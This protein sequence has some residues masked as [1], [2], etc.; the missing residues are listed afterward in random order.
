MDR[1][2][3]RWIG[4]VLLLIGGLID[5]APNVNPCGSN[6][7]QVKRYCTQREQN[8]NIC[9]EENSMT[10]EIYGK[11]KQNE[12]SRWSEGEGTENANNDRS[13]P[14]GFQQRD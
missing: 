1:R 6:R 2:V 5:A 4:G 8:R 9:G 10:G 14:H 3:D 13:L 12:H 11:R 7:G